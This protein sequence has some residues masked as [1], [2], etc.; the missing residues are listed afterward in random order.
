M[1]TKLKGSFYTISEEIGNAVT[2]GIG[3]L[4]AVFG[5]VALLIRAAGSPLATAACAIYGASMILL[6]SMSALYHSLTNKKTKRVLRVCDHTSIFL[7]I[8]GT[9]T[10]YTLI[11]LSGPVGWTIA[12]IVWG[13]AVFGIILNLIS[14]ERFKKI[15]MVCYVA[16]GWCVVLAIVP[17][18][19]SLALPGVLLLVLG[20]VLYTAGI[21]FY[22][23]KS[24]RYAHVIWHLFVLAGAVAQFL[25]IYLY[26]L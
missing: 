17:L 26:V 2:H 20:G 16:S 23:R 13:T 7:L 24:V 14:V 5:A 11:T 25:S 19:R 22:K 1:D 4:L 21:P 18:I 10:P 8:A 15:S 9:Y 6:F 12:G 3:A